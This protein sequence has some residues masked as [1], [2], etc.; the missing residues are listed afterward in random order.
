MTIVELANIV[1][2]LIAKGYLHEPVLMADGTE[3][4]SVSFDGDALWLSDNE[5]RPE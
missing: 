5:E 1:D 2:A 4:T 3:I